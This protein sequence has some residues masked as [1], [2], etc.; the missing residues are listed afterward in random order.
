MTGRARPAAR[1]PAAPEFPARAASSP[2]LLTAP[3]N[4]PVYAPTA[5]PAA[6]ATDRRRDRRRTQGNAGGAADGGAGERAFVALARAAIRILVAADRDTGR[7][8]RA[9]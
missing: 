3:A 1:R 5:R 9:R 8:G 4:A 6:T 7:A 2:S